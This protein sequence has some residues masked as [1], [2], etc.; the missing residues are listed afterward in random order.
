MKDPYAILGVDRKAS[1]DEIKSAYRKLA[2]KLHPDLNPGDAAVEQRFKEASQAYAILSDPDLRARYDRGEVD[3]SGQEKAARGFH[4]TYAGGGQ[5][6]HPF[7]FGEDI[8]V[9]DIFSEFFGGARMRGGR[10][11]PASEKGED[12]RFAV[13]VSFVE[14]AKGAK[15]RMRLGGGKTLEVTVPAGTE[16]GQ[17]LRLK[18]QGKPGR[19]GGAAGDALIEVTVAPHPHFTRLGLDIYLDLP[20]SLQEAVLGANIKV[21]TLEGKVAMKVPK[22]ANTGHRLRLKGKGIEAGGKTGDQYVILQIVLPDKHDSQLRDFVKRWA[23]FNAF[24][25]RKKAG[26]D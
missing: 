24:D 1:A 20:V 9:D 16:N 13:E 3:A 5:K 17:T 14:A 26:L 2:K 15:K 12:S 4:R 11:R 22:G 10:R 25:P 8:S 19:A 23:G 7:D 21:P 6:A 18:G